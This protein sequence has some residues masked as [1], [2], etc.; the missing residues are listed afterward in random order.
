MDLALFVDTLVEIG[1]DATKW[2]VKGEW[3]EFSKLYFDSAYIRTR[4]ARASYDYLRKHKNIILQGSQCDGGNPNSVIYPEVATYPSL[5][6]SSVTIPS[7]HNTPSYV[8]KYYESDE[9]DIDA[10]DKNILIMKPKLIPRNQVVGMFDFS[11]F[12]KCKKFCFSG[13]L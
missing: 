11:K 13:E 8:R 12:K 4:H 10:K 3:V 1:G 9:S 5:D 6:D 2:S 7:I